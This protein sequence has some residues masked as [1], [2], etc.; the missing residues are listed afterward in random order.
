LVNP[1]KKN[2]QTILLFYPS[3]TIKYSFMSIPASH[4][5]YASE[6]IKKWDMDFYER[7][8]S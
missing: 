8:P 5:S 7:R 1:K 4:F 6:G 3:K 2:F